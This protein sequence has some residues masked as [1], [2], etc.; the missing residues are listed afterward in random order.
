MNLITII[1]GIFHTNYGFYRSQR[2]NKLIYKL[3]SYPGQI[4]TRQQIL[5]DI[6]GPEEYV[7]SHTLDVHMSRLRERFK[8]NTDSQIK[9]IAE[10]TPDNIT[11]KLVK[12]VK[13]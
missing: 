2:S 13:E 10:N 7:D 8:N 1:I 12:L 4:F 3:L 9:V 11:I 5:D 6:W